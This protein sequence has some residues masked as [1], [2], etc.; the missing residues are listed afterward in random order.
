V[1][2]AALP[3][4]EHVTARLIEIWSDLLLSSAVGRDT[5]F[6]DHGGT[7]LTAVRIR[8]RIRAEF[9]RDVDL[10]DLLDEA[11][12]ARVA[13]LISVAPLWRGGAD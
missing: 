10:V 9:G 12:P 7:S 6:Q 2:P 5:D 11:T 13:A 1:K 8:S 4:V 3:P